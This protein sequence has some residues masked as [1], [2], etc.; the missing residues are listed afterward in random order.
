MSVGTISIDKVTYSPE[1]Y[2]Y[3]R[4][5]LP[6]KFSII[7]SVPPKGIIYLQSHKMSCTC[8]NFSRPGWFRP[9]HGKP[10]C[11]LITGYFSERGERTTFT[12]SRP[13]SFI[14]C[15]Q[16]RFAV[17]IHLHTSCMCLGQSLTVSHRGHD[18]S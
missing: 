15:G 10:F 6:V 13:Y 1:S 9:K 8:H 18:W 12:R 11:K 7:S 16:K 14:S 2:D 4:R 3:L 5:S 17:L